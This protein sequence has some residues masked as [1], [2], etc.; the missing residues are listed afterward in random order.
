MTKISNQYSLTNV[1]FADT[2]NGR[3]GI[4]TETP[5]SR[6]D[7]TSSN[8]G[9]VATNLVIKNS[10]GGNTSG[11][12]GVGL[13]FLADGGYSVTNHSASLIALSNTR[14]QTGGGTDLLFATHNNSSGPTTKMTI[15]S[16]GNVGIG[17]T[18]PSTQLDVRGTPSGDWGNLTVFDTRS[19]ATGQGGVVTFSGYKTSTT[20][21]NIFAKIA[22]GNEN[23]NGTENGYLSF[24]TN[25]G[26][27]YAERMRIV[28][29]GNV[30][31]GTTSPVN[32]TNYR[33]LHIS[34]AGTSSSAILYLTNSDLSL[35]G[36]LFA[37]GQALRVTIGT[38][39]NHPFTIATNDTERMRITSGGDL[40]ISNTDGTGKIVVAGDDNAIILRSR[41]TSAGGAPYQFYLQ[42]SLGEVSMGNYRSSVNYNNPSDYR[43]KED[44]KEFNGLDILSSIN[45]Y[46]FK[47]KESKIRNYGIIAHELQEVIPYIVSGKKDELFEDGSIKSQQVDISKLVPILGKAIQEQTQIIKDLETRIV[48]LESK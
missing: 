4:G 35:R 25:N 5:V 40:L 12:Q 10:A 37:E 1:L 47:W 16:A 21:A 14:S 36:L 27:A 31:I 22:G 20:A 2:T 32:Y 17:T 38:Q 41:N 34:G 24:I 39:S 30:G 8:S 13:Y 7:I 19:A 11:N 6:L 29:G 48:T 43:L 28:S 44:L 46:D 15:T 42:H 23:G 26:T 33:S 45:F 9:A 3:V 18:S